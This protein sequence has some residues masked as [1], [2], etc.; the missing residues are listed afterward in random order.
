MMYKYT[1]RKSTEDFT[2]MI[3]IPTVGIECT[4]EH[5]VESEGENGNLTIFIILSE[6]P[7][8]P[9]VLTALAI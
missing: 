1:I 2:C 8:S 3:F 7:L 4:D 9:P 6:M 5:R